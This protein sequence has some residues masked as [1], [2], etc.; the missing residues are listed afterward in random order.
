MRHQRRH[1]TSDYHISHGSRAIVT[2]AGSGIG[3]A[4]A[5]ELGRRG[6]RVVC[7]DVDLDAAEATARGISTAGVSAL[8]I[9][10]DVSSEADVRALVEEAEA[11]FGEP[12][13]L[14]VNNA[15]IGAGGAV[16]GETS[17][18]DWRRTV[19]VNLWGVIHGCHVVAPKLR[20]AGRG[21]I[22]N[23]ASAAAFASAPRMSAYNVTKAGVLALSETLAAELAGSGV[24][25]SVVCP[26][27]VTTNI[28]RDGRIS[29]DASRFAE[30]LM[31][32]TG[33]SPDSVARASLDALDRG[34]LYV[35]PQLDARAIWRMKR[36]LPATYVRGLGLIERAARSLTRGEA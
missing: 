30:R 6:G 5:D 3:R 32:W 4:F 13:G 8:A 2:G 36:A 16:V 27:F 23:V 33:V 12:V 18:D 25:V 26:T 24:A 35:L 20:A 9:R 10:C 15:G 7:S 31:A 1:P 22:I 28:V 11:W 21:G 29:T 19:D 14:I 34:E 17:M